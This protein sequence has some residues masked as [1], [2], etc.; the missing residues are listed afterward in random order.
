VDTTIG[1]TRMMFAT[2]LMLTVGAGMLLG[3]MSVGEWLA[4]GVLPGLF[5]HSVAR[6]FTVLM[7]ALSLILFVLYMMPFIWDRVGNS[8]RFR[9]TTQISGHIGTLGSYTRVV[10]AGA[11]ILATGYAMVWGGMQAGEWLTRN[12]LHALVPH[13]IASLAAYLVPVIGFVLLVL[14]IAPWLWN[15][16]TGCGVPSWTY[17]A[18]GLTGKLLRIM[19]IALLILAAVAIVLS[20]IR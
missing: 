13:A 11:L 19:L 3:G 5:P 10:V 17:R 2:T 8:S 18:R 7:P 20:M 15:R 6:P 9:W 14:Y 1:F 4:R 16:V 12:I